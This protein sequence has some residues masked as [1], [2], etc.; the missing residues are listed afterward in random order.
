MCKFFKKR[1]KTTFK[2]NYVLF[3]I[4]M[5]L[6]CKTSKNIKNEISNSNDNFVIAFGETWGNFL[7][8][9]ER[10]KN[11]IV[12]SK[13]K[14]VVLLSGDRHISEFS[15]TKVTN[16]SYPLIDFTSSGLT[17]VY[18]NFSSEKNKYKIK[19]VVN[20]ISFGLLIFNFDKNRIDMQMRGRDNKLLQEINQV[21]P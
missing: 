7:L 6:S 17:H 13:V 16:L 10:L 14:G 8:E 20:E 11:T 21:Y 12:N 5:I 3:L 4:L 19:N 9:L 2:I 1:H 18:D 15:K